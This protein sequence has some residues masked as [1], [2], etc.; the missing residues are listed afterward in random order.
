M[1]Q[2]TIEIV[3]VDADENM[4]ITTQA[5]IGLS[6]ALFVFDRIENCAQ[7]FLLLLKFSNSDSFFFLEIILW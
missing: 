7:L 4:K 2:R 1:M 3:C 6:L 5:Y